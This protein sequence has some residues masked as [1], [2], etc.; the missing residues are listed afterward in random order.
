MEFTDLST[1]FTEKQKVGSF[2]YLQNY[3]LEKTENKEKFFIGRL[4]GNETNL[5]GKR[6]SKS[7]IPLNLLHEMLT[8]AGIQM[9]S[10]EDIDHYVNLYITSCRNSSLLSVWDSGMYAQAKTYYNFL[11]K[12]NPTQKR[13]CAHALEPFYFMDHPEYKFNQVFK[14]KKVLIITSHKAT[15]IKQLK[16]HTGIFSKQIFDESTEFHVYKP[17]QQ[18]AGNHDGNSWT[19]HLEKMKQELSEVV[20]ETFDFDIAL[21][22]CGGFGMLVSDYIFSHLGKSVMYVGGGLQL[23]FGINGNRWKTHP[24]ILK[25]INKKWA[26]VLN[27]DKPPSLSLNPRL[28]E[29]SC[30]W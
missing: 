24:S 25:L 21:V 18:N 3:L 5:C 16:N 23:F 30:Y 27:E 7:D 2:L 29:N 9:R 10:S 12:T 19:F 28:C 15:T 8:G 14:N 11:D 20:N 22:S 17:A 6:L 13:I 26:N 4:S 1:A